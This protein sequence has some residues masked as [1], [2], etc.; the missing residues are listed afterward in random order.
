MAYF[1]F[2]IDINDKQCLIVGGGNVA[3][4]KVEVLSSYGVRIKVVAP[5][6]CEGIL[7]LQGNIVTE[8][9]N[10]LDSDLEEAFFVIAASDHMEL[11]QYISILCKE[12]N[13][14]VNVVD[15]KEHCSFLF[16]A[17]VKK[18]DLT[19]GITTAGNSPLVAHDIRVAIEEMLPDYYE[20]LISLLGK[21][22]PRIKEEIPKLKHRT[23]AFRE[24][25]SEGMKAKGKVTEDMVTAIID[26][27]RS[28]S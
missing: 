6:I 7:Q 16:P 24:L 21:Y 1:P 15:V 9:R 3:L 17:L 8:E 12:K 2:F 10:F 14:L 11:N 25:T 19:V 27:Y 13:I 20:E 18:G 26:K 23:S 22:R 28:L 5:R 4:R